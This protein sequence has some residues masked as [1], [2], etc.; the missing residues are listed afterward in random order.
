MSL[1]FLM[2]HSLPVKKNICFWF[3]KIKL[4]LNTT[5]FCDTG[6]N[7]SKKENS[8]VVSGSYKILQKNSVLYCFIRNHF[9]TIKKKIIRQKKTNFTKVHFFVSEKSMWTT[10]LF[11]NIWWRHKIPMTSQNSKDVTKFR[12]KRFFLLAYICK[13]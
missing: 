2:L 6:D 10:R 8:K 4:L 7:I 1:V 12:R 9:S 11:F 5:T 13:G 3:P